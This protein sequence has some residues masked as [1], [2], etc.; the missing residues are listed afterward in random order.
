MMVYIVTAQMKHDVKT[1]ILAVLFDPDD[2]RNLADELDSQYNGTIEIEVEPHEVRFQ[3][4]GD[5][6]CMISSKSH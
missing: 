5:Y 6:T 1:H 4:G 3:I 2:A